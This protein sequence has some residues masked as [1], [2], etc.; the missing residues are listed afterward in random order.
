MGFGDR[1]EISIGWAQRGSITAGS[2]FRFRKVGRYLEDLL[3][4][5]RSMPSSHACIE[6]I[7]PY[8]NKRYM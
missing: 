4:Y 8:L 3:I 6:R 2:G 1:L 7:I 5:S